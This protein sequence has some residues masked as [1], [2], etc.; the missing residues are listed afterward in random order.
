MAQETAGTI[1]IPVLKNEILPYL[2]QFARRRE[3]AAR[4]E[5]QRLYKQQQE[6]SKAQIPEM[7]APKGGYFTPYVAQKR[8][9]VV[10]ALT[11]DVATGKY[12]QAQLN[13]QSRAAISSLQDIDAQQSFTS[14]LLNKEAQKLN[15]MGVVGATPGLI[16]TY[17]SQGLSGA[18]PDAFFAQPHTEGFRQYALKDYRNISPAKLGE[19]SLK[20]VKPN[21]IKVE[22]GNKTEDFEYFDVFDVG[23]TKDPS[24]GADVITAM[25]VNIPKAEM[26][27]NADPNRKALKEAWVA[28][29]SAIIEA[30]PAYMNLPPEQKKEEA[31]KKAT[32]EFY[33]DAF[34]N[35]MV[36]KYGLSY[37]EPRMGRG[38]G[39]SSAAKFAAGMDEI[40]LPNDSTVPVY[41]ISSTTE[42][43][44]DVSIPQNTPYVNLSTN[45]SE[46]FSGSGGKLL[47][48]SIGYAAK[49]K[50]TNE[51]IDPA[52][53]ATTPL[54]QV[55]FVPGVYGIKSTLQEKG[56][57]FISIG[58]SGL[59]GPTISGDQIFLKEGLPGWRTLADKILRA[60][61]TSY[62]KAQ[63]DALKQMKARFSQ[64][65]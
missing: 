64:R 53:Y 24:T 49:K 27:I 13:T 38:G 47:S 6:L 18:D 15:E 35:F 5:A 22:K 9:E 42:G 41:G 61:N 39:R 62:Q 56:G 8:K 4:L 1:G 2:D 46:T 10:D 54:G 40:R 16:S 11:K 31:T 14:D 7:P 21:K 37:D 44:V 51:F 57:S 50:G 26:V 36:Q 63:N 60:Q 34:K 32:E 25:K 58:G 52:K 43:G 12:N 65:F 59:S 28:S 20:G 29:R 17:V 45:K 33:Q 48:P 55:E 3:Q 30:D 19:L 23:R